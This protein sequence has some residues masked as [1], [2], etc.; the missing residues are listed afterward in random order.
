[1]VLWNISNK[2]VTVGNRAQR[3]YLGLTHLNR[4]LSNFLPGL[5]TYSFSLPQFNGGN[6]INVHAV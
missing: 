4:I 3:C 2:S 6:K 5:L 1:M